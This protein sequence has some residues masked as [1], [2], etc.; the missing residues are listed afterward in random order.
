V[1]VR[2]WLSGPFLSAGGDSRLSLPPDL[3]IDARL[4]VHGGALS[5]GALPAVRRVLIARAP[6]NV[7]L[8]QGFQP[9]GSEGWLRDGQPPLI[10]LDLDADYIV[11]Q[12]R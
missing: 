9:Y 8:P 6:H 12:D 1:Q 11:F 5:I 10:S 3:P 4:R 2:S 7:V